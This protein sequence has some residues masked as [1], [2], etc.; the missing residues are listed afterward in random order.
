MKRQQVHIGLRTIK[1]AA[2]VLLA[3]LAVAMGGL[4]QIVFTRNASKLSLSIAL[5]RKRLR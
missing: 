4:S 1:T 5:L 3:S 2:A